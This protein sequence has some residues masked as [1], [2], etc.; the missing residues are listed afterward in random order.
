MIKEVKF[1]RQTTMSVY[2]EVYGEN[3]TEAEIDNN[4]TIFANSPFGNDIHIDG[5]TKAF[6][7]VTCYKD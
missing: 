4:R 2:Y 7:R 5:T 3:L 1:I 6:A